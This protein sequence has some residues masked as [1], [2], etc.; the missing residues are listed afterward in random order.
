MGTLTLALYYSILGVLALYGLHRAFLVALYLRHRG[1]EPALPPAPPVWPRVTIQ[2][3]LYNEMYVAGRLLDAVAALDY[4]RDRFEIQVLDDSTDETT[5]I[6]AERVAWCRARGISVHHLRRPTREGYKAGALAYGL[7]RATGELVAVFDADFL[8]APDFLKLLVPHLAAD[9]ELGMVQAR[10]THLNRDYSLLTRAQAILLDGHFLIEHFARQR[11][12]CFFNFNGTAGL[13][14]RRAIEEAGGWQH[15]TVTEDLDISYRAQLA[16]WRFLFLPEVTVPAELP[17]EVNAFKAQQQ[18]WAKGAMQTGR[19]L[20][21]RLLGAPLPLRV[22]LEGFVHLTNNLAYPL[23]VGLALLIVPAMLERRGSPLALL[24]AIDLPLFLAAMVSVLAFYAASQLGQP[25]ERR[26]FVWQLPAVLGMGIGLAVG[27]APAV[28]S[29]L[30]S[31][32]GVFHR[33]PK[34]AVRWRG[35]S[36]SAKRYRTAVSPV[37]V[38][39]GLLSVYFLAAMVVAGLGGMWLSLPFLWLFLQGFGC[40]FLQS[41]VPL[42]RRARSDL[43]APPRC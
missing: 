39:E 5:A 2:L 3:P 23:M 15:D 8:P 34:Y 31:R 12:G 14:R 9:P 32:G 21:P 13:W 16:G 19:K 1:R 20:L 30:L 22:K 7:E 29:G 33:T 28:L 6:V 4:P 43:T 26:R 25:T 27:N 24:I 41:A 18:R 37:L 10:W 17:V 11:S 38:I 40:M 36:W 35:D 42:L